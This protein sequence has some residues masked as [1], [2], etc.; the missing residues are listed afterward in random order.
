MD[1][2]RIRRFKIDD[3]QALY[4]LLSDEEV[5][6]YIEP[7]YSFPQ[8][9]AFLHSAG[10]A[11]S[12]L[13]Y[14]VETA[15]R[16][17]VGYVIYHDYDEESK[18]IGWVLR[19][20]FWG[21]GYAGKLTKQLIEKAYAEGKSA[22]LECSPAQ[23]VTKHI[24]EKFGFSYS[25]Q[26]DGCEVYQLDR[27]AWFH[28]ACIDPQ[29][30]VISEYRHPEEPHCYLLCGETEA[31]L[32]DTG[33]GISN[34]RAIVD[35]LTG[36]PLT[37]LTTHVHWD[38]IGA[39]RLFARFAVHE[40]EKD[41]IADCF[42]LSTERVKAQLCSEPCSFPASFDPESYRIFQGEPQ[43]ILHD[44][45]RFDLGGRTVEVIHTPG[46][47]PGHCC[48]YEP[49][50]K[51][52]YSGDLIYK[53]CLDA[54]YPST[55]PQ[56]FYRSVKR[57]RD[58]EIRRIFPGHHDLALPVSLIEEIETAFSLLERQGKLKQGKGVF[59]FGAFQIHI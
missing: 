23:A 30:F 37:V 33:L 27:N 52:L 50:R 35:S 44:G 32:I 19:R 39:H 17:F 7:P 46:H 49:E 57:L 5:M 1:R 2:L 26:R 3:L 10:L 11:L 22:V 53:G 28:V 16:D 29:T 41:W 59:D 58:Y 45:D 13:I 6:R 56:L 25:K 31:V 18:E 21:R 15:N 42:P 9:E 54:F 36:L 8:T 12:P 40:A 20:A 55:D 24:A 43:L 48:F 14:A 34:L 4:E 51:Y 47:S 38:H